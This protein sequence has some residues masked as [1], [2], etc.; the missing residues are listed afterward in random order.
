MNG[1]ICTRGNV[2]RKGDNRKGQVKAERWLLGWAVTL[3]DTPGPLSRATVWGQPLPPVAR[4][5][6]QSVREG[7]IADFNSGFI[8]HP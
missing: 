4:L 7:R 5:L 3:Q 1:N 6:T 8:L 2:T